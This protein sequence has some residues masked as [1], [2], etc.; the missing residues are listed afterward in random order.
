M[1]THPPGAAKRGPRGGSQRVLPCRCDSLTGLVATDIFGGADFLGPVF[2]PSAFPVR[3]LRQDWLSACLP[4][5]PLPARAG[6]CSPCALTPQLH[7]RGGLPSALGWL[8]A[9]A[10]RR[11][12][13]DHMHRDAQGFPTGRSR[14]GHCLPSTQSPP[15]LQ[16][17]PQDLLSGSYLQSSESASLG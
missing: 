7:L 4:G 16:E 12:W 14:A 11:T 6:G 10:F 9:C 17:R 3:G 15:A 8:C 13:A 1:L 2:L 5:L